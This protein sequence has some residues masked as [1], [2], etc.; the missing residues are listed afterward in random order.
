ML[1]AF[2]SPCMTQRGICPQSHSNKVTRLGL[3]LDKLRGGRTESVSAGE[4]KG[5]V[6]DEDKITPSSAPSLGSTDS[7]SH[8]SPLLL[9]Q[10]FPTRHS[11][12]RQILPKPGTREVGSSR[13]RCP[14][15]AHLHLLPDVLP[16]GQE[17]V[18][19]V[20]GVLHVAAVLAVNQ[21]PA[22]GEI[23]NL[24]GNTCWQL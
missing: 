19:R 3:T 6:G 24:L 21:Q 23:T 15:P 9:R 17:V 7:P 22:E 12:L 13:P 1:G 11:Q 16:V 4:M 14:L 18:E 10:T 2:G 8:P 20:L 5:Q